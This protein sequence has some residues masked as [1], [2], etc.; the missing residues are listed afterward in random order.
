MI[1]PQYFHIPGAPTID[2]S[3]VPQAPAGRPAGPPAVPQ[4]RPPAPQLWAPWLWAQ[5][6]RGARGPGFAAPAKLQRLKEV[7]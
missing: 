6:V 5:E 3:S 2:S 1:Y 4:A 7:C